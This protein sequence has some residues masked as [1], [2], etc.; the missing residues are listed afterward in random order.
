MKNLL[1]AVFLL[2][3]S[4]L[5]AQYK[6]Y[7]G[8]WTKINTTY[9]FEFDLVIRHDGTHVKGYFD[10]KVVDY[11]RNSTFGKAYYAKKLGTRAREYVKGTFD[12]D[13]M[14]YYLEG[15]KKTD[16]ETVIGLDTYRLQVDGKGNIHGPTKANNS[17]L[18]RINGNKVL[19][20]LML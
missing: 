3:S 13:K 9:L 12:A 15:Y 1:L 16:P 10:W 7:S 5:A 8:T 17:W 4:S 11:D 14:E 2:L 20:K 18:G 19:V 6:H